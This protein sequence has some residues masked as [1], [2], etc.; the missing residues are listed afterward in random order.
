MLKGVRLAAVSVVVLVGLIVGG[1]GRLFIPPLDSSEYPQ[2]SDP[3]SYIGPANIEI[4][5]VEIS[6][7]HA[8][9]RVSSKGAPPLVIEF[10]YGT[11]ST[12]T[13]AE[14]VQ[15]LIDGQ[16][17]SPANLLGLGVHQIGVQ[18]RLQPQGVIVYIFLAW[19]AIEFIRNCATPLYNDVQKGGWP[20][21][22]KTFEKC[23]TEAAAI[24][25]DLIAR[26]LA[27]KV[28][29]VTELR[30]AIKESIFGKVITWGQLNR[31][32]NKGTKPDIAAI[33][34]ALASNFFKGLVNAFKNIFNQFGILNQPGAKPIVTGV[35]VQGKSLKAGVRYSE[36]IYFSDEDGDVN[37]IQFE[38]WDGRRWVFSSGW[39]FQNKLGV[40]RGDIPYT[41]TCGPGGGT[42]RGRVTLFDLG[43][44]SELLEYTYSCVR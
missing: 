24:V 39:S 7:H 6:E 18:E 22:E 21:T 34:G 2:A 27:S 28:I 43:E 38:V 13:E 37:R 33:V 12:L 23:V 32:F 31:L 44:L 36:Q 4:G 11:R 8:M 14:Q 30:K 19:T 20:P 35:S 17:I 41:V 5:I 3:A 10:R 29:K 26:K 1:C 25:V 9:V 16:V 40:Y 15:I 42:V